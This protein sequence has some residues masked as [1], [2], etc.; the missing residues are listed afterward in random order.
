[1]PHSELLVTWVVRIKNVSGDGNRLFAVVSNETGNK[2]FAEPIPK[3]KGVRKDI[4]NT[5]RFAFALLRLDGKCGDN[6]NACRFSLLLCG[7]EGQ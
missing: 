3:G 1:M 4:V 7:Q 5:R 2:E 6:K